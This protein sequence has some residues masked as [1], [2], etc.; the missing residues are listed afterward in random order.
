M[1]KNKIVEGIIEE[2]SF[3]NKSKIIEDDREYIFK[4]GILG[5]KARVKRTRGKKA[6][7]LEIIE[8]SPLEKENF[9]SVSDRCGGCTYQNMTYDEESQYKKKL[10]EKLFKENSI[11]TDFEYVQSPVYKGYRN[12]MEYT[13]GDEEKNGPLALGLHRRNHFHD[14]VNTE[15]C[16]IVNNDFNVIRAFTRDY[17]DG[18]LEKYNRMSHEGVLRHLVIRRSSIGEILVNL[19]TAGTDFDFTEYFEKLRELELEGNIVGIVHTF[20]NSFADAI[21]PE[22]VEVPF[23][24]DYIY[25]EM[26]GLKFKVSCYSFFQTNTDSAKVLYTLAKNMVKDMDD[27]ILLDLY[28]GTGTI[29]QIL[30][31]YASKA[32][33]I[34]I[35]QDAV[36]SAVENA[37]LNNLDNVEFICDDVFNAV[38]DL[39]YN[40]D[41][42]VLDPPREGINP[43]A[44]ENIINFNPE[45][46]IYISCNPD[47][48]VRDVQV[49]IE[50]GYEIVNLKVLDQFPRTNHLEIVSLLKKI[51]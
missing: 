18:K 11:N 14:I 45:E 3:P 50:K 48:Y 7:L 43:R 26:L 9:C 34:E 2:V 41:I 1:A 39:K 30:G 33:G 6:K 15:N 28:S 46:F 40:P 44:I 12:K 51:N 32:L 4:G 19:V 37:K 49:F 20:N 17:F 31:Q 8:K 23:G 47:T 24:R 29:T 38:K 21:V 16:N 25:E 13:F 36:D 27:K 22:K 10:I 35:V 5:Q 42:I